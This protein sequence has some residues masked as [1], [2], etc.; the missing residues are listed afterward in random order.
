MSDAAALIRDDILNS[1]SNLF[2]IKIYDELQVEQGYL[3]LKWKIETDIGSLF[4]K[5]YNKT[6]Y[7]ENF[8]MILRSP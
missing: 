8:V 4:V 6:R 1:I 7:P 5:Q 2:G 3:N